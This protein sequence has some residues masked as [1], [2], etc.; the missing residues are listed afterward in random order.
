[1][2]LLLATVRPSF[3]SLIWQKRGAMDWGLDSSSFT[4]EVWEVEREGE[5]EGEGKGGIDSMR[6]VSDGLREAWF[7]REKSGTKRSRFR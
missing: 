3:V 7:T 4:D 2:H 6:F 5:G 1:M